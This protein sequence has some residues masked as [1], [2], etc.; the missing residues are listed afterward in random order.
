VDVWA[1]DRSADALTVARANL[2]GLGRRA[3]AVVLAEGP[4]F[5]ALDPALRGTI[6]LVVSNPP[7]VGADEVLPAEVADWEP[8]GALVAGPRGTE[9]LEVLVDQSVRWLTPTGSLVLELAPHQAA[10]I[11]DRARSV[12][13]VDVEVLAD[14][15]GR[16]RAVLARR[17]APS[18][19]PPV[20]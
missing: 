20:R 9:D 18:T 16:D 4:W 17:A 2:T 10:A 3:T 12:G 11:A 14:L 13:F 5:E 19:E 8:S 15:T 7:Y 6:D 1:T